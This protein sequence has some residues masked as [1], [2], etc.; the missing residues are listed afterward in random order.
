MAVLLRR[1]GAPTYT[2]LNSALNVKERHSVAER[3]R[4]RERNIVSYEIPLCVFVSLH[5]KL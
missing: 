3:E 2:N 4:E 5:Y 1:G